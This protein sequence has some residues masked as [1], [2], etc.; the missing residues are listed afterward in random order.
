MNQ[1]TLNEKKPGTPGRKPKL[2]QVVHHLDLGGSE[3]VA[4]S[5]S[6]HLHEQYEIQFFAVRGVE[7]TPVGHA[8]KARLDRLGIP[9]H[10]GTRRVLKKG[11][12]LEAAVRLAQ[13]VGRERPD[14]VHLHTEIP[15]LTHAISQGFLGKASGRPATVTRTLHNTVFWGPW[16]RMGGMVEKRLSDARCVACSD[17]ALAGMQAFRSSNGLPPLSSQTAQV[18]FNGVT[19]PPARRSDQGMPGDRPLRVLIAG[20][21]EP[22]KGLDL[23][24]AILAHAG[25][26]GHP[27]AELNIYGAGTL[28]PDLERWIAGG[29][30]GWNI[31]LSPP[32]P[33]LRKL[34]AEHDLM[35]M[36]SRFEGLALMAAE[37]LV[38]GLP[39]IGTRIGGLIEVL[40]DGYPLVAPAEDTEAMGT[41]LAQVLNDPNHFLTM[42]QAWMQPTEALFGIDRMA[43]EYDSFYQELL[44]NRSQTRQTWTTNPA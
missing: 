12:F 37:A 14:I 29:V 18:I 15:E 21:F 13:T 40:T 6:E 34:M 42:A 44:Q 32:T 5:L 27:S 24:P 30:P 1:Q 43:H 41:L 19:A 10:S 17:A 4:I 2:L 28:Q 22:Q 16:Q 25:A 33:H 9:V 23:L 26:L 38:A 39:T 35:L 11:G 20:R 7:D 3:E 31:T 36:P 8:M